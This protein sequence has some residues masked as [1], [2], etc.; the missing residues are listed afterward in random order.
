MPYLEYFY[1]GASTELKC[2]E[3]AEPGIS[4]LWISQRNFSVH[5]APA[6]GRQAKIFNNYIAKDLEIY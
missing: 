3:N 5:S 1:R 2:S 6:C 4:S